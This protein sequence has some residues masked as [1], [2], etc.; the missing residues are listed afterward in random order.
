MPD[1]FETYA[2]EMR[3]VKV[4]AMAL[5]KKKRFERG[6][7][8]FSLAVAVCLTVALL[9]HSLYMPDFT[10]TVYA[11][12]SGVELQKGESVLLTMEDQLETDMIATTEGSNYDLCTVLFSVGCEGAKKIKY[13]IVGEQT[14]ENRYD[15]YDSR[16]WFAEKVKL[17]PEDIRV[18]SSKNPSYPYIY[19]EWEEVE[20]FYGYRYYGSEYSSE[21]TD[22]E[23]FPSRL[24]VK[25]EKNKGK[26]VFEDTVI[27]VEVELQN[28]GKIDK[29]LL[30]SLDKKLTKTSKQVCLTIREK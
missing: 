18:P 23:N 13:T 17:S 8:G 7:I 16:L 1:I 20:E 15:M 22:M 19:A 4:P 9:L 3:E 26:Y 2:K 21:I 25:V 24:A 28:G 27:L 29:E 5:K 11:A 10:L 14:Y 30:L 12:G 6:K